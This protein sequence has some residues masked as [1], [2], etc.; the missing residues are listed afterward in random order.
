MD[1]QMAI[2]RYEN[3]MLGKQKL[4][5]SGTDQEKE[6]AA[7]DIFRYV[8]EDLLG[9]TPEVAKD[10]LN[11]EIAHKMHL[12]TLIKHY[13]HCPKDIQKD[14]DYDYF[15]AMAFPHEVVYDEREGLVTMYKRI[16]HGE[17]QRFPQHYFN[18]DH[19][20]YK[21]S[22]LLM[23]VIDNKLPVNEKRISN[24]YALFADSKEINKKFKEWRLD[25]SPSSA[26]TSPLEYLHYSL[27]LDLSNDF[28]YSYYSFSN[29]YTNDEKEDKKSV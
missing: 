18:G 1:K 23:Y 26:F 20:R 11:K 28:L 2:A 17:Q 19:G 6:K 14:S 3:M 21:S 25:D 27:P 29:V 4:M 22:L 13:I 8:I 9:W 15:V 12:D 16:I 7:L 5:L 24:L 10:C